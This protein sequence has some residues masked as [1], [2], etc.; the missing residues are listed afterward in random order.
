MFEST[1]EQYGNDIAVLFF[2]VMKFENHP[3]YW[4]RGRGLQMVISMGRFWQTN[5]KNM[6]KR[7]KL[8]SRGRLSRPDI[9]IICLLA[10]EIYAGLINLIIA[11]CHFA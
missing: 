5:S 11:I 9:L 4:H 10:N 1:K 3:G 2:G 8:E 6:L 7:V